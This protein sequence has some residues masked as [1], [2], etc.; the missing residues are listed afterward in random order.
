MIPHDGDGDLITEC[1][2]YGDLG[3]DNVIVTTQIF[4]RT[5]EEYTV[6]QTIF[7]RTHSFQM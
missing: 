1:R 4:R 7:N 3:E 5:E 2:F 6:T